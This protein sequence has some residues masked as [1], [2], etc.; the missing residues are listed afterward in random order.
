MTINAGLVRGKPHGNPVL[1]GHLLV[2]IAAG[3]FLAFGV[4]QF[5]CFLVKDMVTRLTFLL[6]RLF[7]PEMKR[8]IQ[9]HGLPT[10]FRTTFLGVTTGTHHRTGLLSGTH[11][12][13][14]AGNT[15]GMIEIHYHLFIGLHQAL[16]FDTEPVRA[17]FLQ[18]ARRTILT[19]FFQSDRVLV[20]EKANARAPTGQTLSMCRYGVN[21]P[22]LGPVARI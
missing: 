3:A 20:M 19:G 22:L 1:L 18:M 8:V 15:V 9:S 4:D 11:P 10:R 12:L 6:Q 21:R 17:C 14:V 7:M 5:F 2:A 16:K 13:V